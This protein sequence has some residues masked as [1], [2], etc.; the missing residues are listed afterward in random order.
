M[1]K[2]IIANFQNTIILVIPT[3][4]SDEKVTCYDAGNICFV[5]CLF[6]F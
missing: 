5:C 4:L 2:R 1:H 3:L 6:R